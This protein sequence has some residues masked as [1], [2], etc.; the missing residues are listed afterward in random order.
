MVSIYYFFLPRKKKLLA[1]ASLFLPYLPDSNE[2]AKIHI[3][4][5]KT[6]VTKI[7]SRNIE[8]KVTA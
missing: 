2:T 6:L 5:G 8:S 1:F 7:Q 3:Q 4:G